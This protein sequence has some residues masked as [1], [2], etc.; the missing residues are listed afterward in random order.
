MENET[1]TTN[2]YK[3]STEYKW[4]VSDMTTKESRLTK[5]KTRKTRNELQVQEKTKRKTKDRQPNSN[6][7]WGVKKN[8]RKIHVRRRLEYLVPVRSIKY[9]DIQ[10][11][12]EEQRERPSEYE[13]RER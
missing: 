2:T 11:H 4:L 5:A 12:Q 6:L 1:S 8:E 7:A 3:L 10:Q 13:R 9:V